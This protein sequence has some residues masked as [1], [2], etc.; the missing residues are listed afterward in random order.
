[1][2]V[3]VAVG[4]AAVDGFNDQKAARPARVRPPRPN[5]ATTA[6]RLARVD[7]SVA[8]SAAGLTSGAGAAGRVGA[9][10]DGRV[11]AVG[12]GSPAADAMIRANSNGEANRSPGSLAIARVSAA[13]T[14]AD[15]P[16][17]SSSSADN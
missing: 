11:A 10:I 15:S 5:T 17:A 13:P 14:P 3:A 9:V 2:S 7:A 16:S 4:A 12:S 6:G 8:R 1:M